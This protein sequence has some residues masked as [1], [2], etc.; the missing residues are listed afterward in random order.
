MRYF[1]VLLSLSFCFNAALAVDYSKLV[2][3]QP[4]KPA[5]TA[6]SEPSLLGWVSAKSAEYV[7]PITAFVGA[8]AVPKVSELSAS[9]ST[10]GFAKSVKNFGR[11]FSVVLVAC[12][13]LSISTALSF[14]GVQK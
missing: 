8:I 2:P 11:M 13:V 14:N 4:P 12:G 5:E 9:V 3:R 1:V 10:P 6:K 7:I